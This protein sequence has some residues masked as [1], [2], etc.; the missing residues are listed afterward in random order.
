MNTVKEF[1]ERIF[2]NVEQ[3]MIGKRSAVELVLVALLCRGHLLIEDVPGTGKTVLA[4]SIAR[5]IGSSFKRIQFTPDLLPSDVTGISIFNQQNHEFEFRSG[6]IFAQIVLADEINRATPKTQSAMLEAMEER[7]ITVDGATYGLP[8]PFIVLATQ[9]PI[10]YEGTFPLP[11]AQLDRFLLRLHMG[12]PDRIDEIAILKRQRQA[13]PLEHLHPV[14]QIDDLLHFQEAI[15]EVYV[16]D[17]ISEY[18][19]TLAAATRHHEDVYLGASARG[20]LALYRTAQAWAAIHGRDY[21][22]PDDVK[23]L[24]LP[25]LGH[26]MIISPAARIRSVTPAAVITDVLTAVAVPG[27]R[28]GR[29]YDRVGM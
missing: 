5:S 10:E 15:K 3:V 8:A 28:A 4:K 24:A 11:E 22:T 14:A 26:R 2:Q 17:L 13:H 7:Q 25:V 18:I 23:T 29:R 16:D 27:A 9:N 20:S 1:A 19:V 12:Y 21:V 6:P